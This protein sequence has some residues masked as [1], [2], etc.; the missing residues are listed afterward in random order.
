MPLRVLHIERN[1]AKVWRN[2][3]IHWATKA[4]PQQ[5]E[6]RAPLPNSHSSH[7]ASSFCPVL[8]HNARLST[9]SILQVSW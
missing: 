8:M 6:P 9:Y 7:S 2:A 5:L 1:S 3:H 4:A